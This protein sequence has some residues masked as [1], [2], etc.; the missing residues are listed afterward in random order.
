MRLIGLAVVDAWLLR[1]A[2][3]HETRGGPMKLSLLVVPVLLLGAAFPAFG[4]QI[5]AADQEMMKIRQAMSDTYAAA[6]TKKD[7]AAIADHYTADVIIASLCPESSPAVGREAYAKRTE[8]G[9]K[10]GFR[11]YSGKVK[12]A[13]LLSDGLAWSTGVSTFTI[14]DKDGKAQQVRGNWIDMLRREGNEWRVSFQAFARTPC[15]P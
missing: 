10:A 7:V 2:S 13:H 12:E 11:D 3:P 5:S 6:V 4:Q 1:A 9:L 15:S 8:A 14:T